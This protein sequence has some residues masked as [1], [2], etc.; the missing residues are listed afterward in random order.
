MVNRDPRESYHDR[1]AGRYEE[2][3]RSHYW[4]L[5]REISWRHLARFLPRERPARALD[6][7][8]GPGW[9]G[10][11]LLKA[12]LEVTFL[13]ISRAMVDQARRTVAELGRP[14]PCRFVQADMERMEAVES[15]AYHFATAQGDTLSFTARPERALKELHRVLRPGGR[16][17]LS[18][19]HKAAAARA[20]VTKG[21]LEELPRF[22][23]DGRSQWLARRPEERFPLRMV[24]PEE[25]ERMRR[26][27]GFATLGLVGKLALF[28]R[29]DEKL[30]AA[31]PRR[32]LVALEERVHARPHWLGL[33]HHFQVAVE[34]EGGTG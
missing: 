33:C 10:A 9:F 15:G 20:Y 4:R 7:G 29:E 25:L 32:R 21:R 19:D 18:V 30:L 28:R 3:Y 6:L 11:R 31:T 34:K 27:Q 17:V 24:E 1:I 14:E 26:R 16:A 22:L 8:C 23:R 5:Y 2:V 12:G 13:D